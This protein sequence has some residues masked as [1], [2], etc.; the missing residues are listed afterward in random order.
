MSELKIPIDDL[1]A[2]PGMEDLKPGDIIHVTGPVERLDD[3]RL[4]D[5]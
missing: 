4:N 5:D 1:W 3:D 2:L